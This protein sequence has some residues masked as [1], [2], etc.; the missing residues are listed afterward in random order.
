MGRMSKKEKAAIQKAYP[1]L[2]PRNACASGCYKEYYDE[3]SKVLLVGSITSPQGINRG[4]YYAADCN[5]FWWLIDELTKNCSQ[6][7]TFVD[8]KQKLKDNERGPKSCY[9]HKIIVSKFEANLKS[10]HLAIA[11]VTKKCEFKE[12][13]VALDSQII[14]DKTLVLNIRK[15][16]TIFKKSKIIAAVVNSDFVKEIWISKISKKIAGKYEL[17]QVESPSS[18]KRVKKEVKSVDWCKKITPYL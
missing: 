8:L 18:A 11:D 16:Q 10:W 3:D 13:G 14:K 12:D 5:Q 17:I 15:I 7:H 1:K 9:E 4:Y 2:T 6:K